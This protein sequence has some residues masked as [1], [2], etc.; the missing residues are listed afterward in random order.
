MLGGYGT[1]VL[2]ESASELH[3]GLKATSAAYYLLSFQEVL[4]Q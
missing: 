3:E 2:I 1:V 4:H